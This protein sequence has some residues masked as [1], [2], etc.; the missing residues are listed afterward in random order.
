VNMYRMAILYN[1]IK[2]IDVNNLDT[3]YA[4]KTD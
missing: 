3:D 1:K 2:E 4:D